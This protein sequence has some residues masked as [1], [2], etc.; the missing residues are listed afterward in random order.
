LKHFADSE[1]KMKM[2][3]DNIEELTLLKKE[4]KASQFNKKYTQ[5]IFKAVVGIFF[6]FFFFWLVCP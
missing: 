3:C 2:G 4:G 6:F 5:A 1:K